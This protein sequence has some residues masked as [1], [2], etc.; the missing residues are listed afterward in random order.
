MP[1]QGQTLLNRGNGFEQIQ[2]QAQAS[3]GAKV[4]ANPGGQGQVTYEDGCTV[5]VNPGQIYT[6]QPASPCQSG[7]LL[8]IN[9]YAVGAA[10]IGGTVAA[11][12][13]LSASP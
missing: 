3:A 4:V 10:L 1:I 6:I 13:L 2:G 12:V 5:T 8:P 9:G 7:A 11:V